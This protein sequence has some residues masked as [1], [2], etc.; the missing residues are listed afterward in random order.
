MGADRER[1]RGTDPPAVHHARA[2]AER[3]GAAHV[4]AGALGGEVG[5]VL[6]PRHTGTRTP[7]SS[8]MPWHFAPLSVSKAKV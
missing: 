3:L 6:G 5:R 7:L 8:M 2:V 1:V 4:P